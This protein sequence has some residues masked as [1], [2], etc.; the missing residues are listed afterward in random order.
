MRGRHLPLRK[1]DG[2]DTIVM[3]VYV[4]DLLA[5]GIVAAAVVRYF[6]S[7]ASLSIKDLGRVS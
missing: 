6:A 7:L 5:T 4:D 3:V 2:K 1:R